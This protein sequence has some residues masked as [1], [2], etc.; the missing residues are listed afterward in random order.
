MSLSHPLGLATPCVGPAPGPG[1][2]IEAELSQVLRQAFRVL[3]E[4]G[5]RDTDARV[6]VGEG[7]ALDQAECRRMQ[8][9]ERGNQ[10]HTGTSDDRHGTR[11]DR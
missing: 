4:V 10:E 8:R 5:G 7:D 11:P 2:T 6:Q 9:D 1:R 3:Q